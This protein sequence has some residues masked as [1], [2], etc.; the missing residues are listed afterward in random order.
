MRC[1]QKFVS[2]VIKHILFIIKH[3]IDYI[4][5]LYIRLEIKNR[6]E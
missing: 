1:L 5:I 2:E 4:L 6:G 3:L